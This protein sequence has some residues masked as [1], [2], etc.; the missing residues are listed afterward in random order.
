MNATVTAVDRARD[1]RPGTPAG[2]GDSDVQFSGTQMI[3]GRRGHGS[4]L[5]AESRRATAATAAGLVT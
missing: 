5:R 3:S 1:D 4:R 2:P